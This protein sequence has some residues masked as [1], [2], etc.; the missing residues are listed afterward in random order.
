MIND[1]IA[2]NPYE[3]S[4]TLRRKLQKKIGIFLI[5]IFSL[6]LITILFISFLLFP[7]SIHSDSMNPLLEEN[8]QVFVSPLLVPDNP[9]FLRKNVIYRGDIVLVASKNYQN[10]SFLKKTINTLVG[11][12]T[13]RKVHPFTS[14]Q[15]MTSQN[16]LRRVIGLPG[17]TIYISNYTVYIKPHNSQYF[18]TEFEVSQKM[19]D[20]LYTV[21]GSLPVF[22]QTLGTVGT[23]N[24]F[25]LQ[26][27]EYF[28]LSDNR[29]SG[30][31]SRFWGAITKEEIKGKA[32]LRYFPLKKIETL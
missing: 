26:D 3:F 15:E 7:V 31:D 1:R 20:I 9:F 5:F 12:V 6:S 28:V 14:T 25:T 29:I 13:F 16:V 27:D 10:L 30:I 18:L 11:F 32:L 24:E 4:F 23:M 8:N 17:D 22:D 21:D 19:Y 2:S